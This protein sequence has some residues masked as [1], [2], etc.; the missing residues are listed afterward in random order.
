MDN[1]YIQEVVVAVKEH[2][3]NDLPLDEVQRL[4]LGMYGGLDTMIS[5]FSSLTASNKFP[6]LKLI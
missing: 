4:A 2:F 5:N 6:S 3:E 1:K